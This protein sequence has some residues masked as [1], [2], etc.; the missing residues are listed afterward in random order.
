MIVAPLCTK[1]PPPVFDVTAQPVSTMASPPKKPL[2][3]LFWAEQFWKVAAKEQENPDP[4]L[5]FEVQFEIVELLPTEI[6]LPEPL[7]LA[8]QLRT[9]ALLPVRMPM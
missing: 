3:V 8:M 7:L 1:T 2:P 6:P 4:L 9:T 5:L